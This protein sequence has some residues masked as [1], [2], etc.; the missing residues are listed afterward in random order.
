MTGVTTACLRA[1]QP[2]PI[3]DSR[4]YCHK[5]LRGEPPKETLCLDGWNCD[6][7]LD[8]EGPGFKKRNTYLDL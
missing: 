5:L 4:F 1:L 7:I 8:E 3:P 6:R 2:Q